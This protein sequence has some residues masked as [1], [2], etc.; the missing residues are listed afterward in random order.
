MRI[1]TFLFLT[2]LAACSPQA[3]ERAQAAPK[4]V[5]EA[6]TTHDV[7]G[8]KVVPL[9][10]TQG[11]KSHRFS[12]EVAQSEAE[13]EKGLM[14]RTKMGADEG[15]IFPMKP[16]RIASFWMRNT[17]IPLDIIFVGQDGKVINI[18]ANAEPETLTPRQSLGI[19]SAVL[20]LNGGRAAE[21]GIG[22]G[23]LVEW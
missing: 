2:V 6:K 16:A 9:T 14:F 19:A 7:S 1:L 21:L 10:V 3:S 11:G 15:M 20:E 18:S 13:Q 8:L 23:A 12:V 5:V 17:L 4:P 22:P